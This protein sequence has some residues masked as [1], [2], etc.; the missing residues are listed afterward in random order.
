MFLAWWAH[1]ELVSRP[2]CHVLSGA[3]QVTRDKRA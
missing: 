1:L 3:M 2:T